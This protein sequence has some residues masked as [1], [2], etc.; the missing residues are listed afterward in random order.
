LSPAIKA[1]DA[2]AGATIEENGD[3]RLLSS[4][5]RLSKATSAG[6]DVAADVAMGEVTGKIAG[7]G[8]TKL[9]D[10]IIDTKAGRT[11]VETVVEK[12]PSVAK[13]AWKYGDDVVETGIKETLGNTVGAD[14][15]GP[16]S[17]SIE[18]SGKP[19]DSAEGN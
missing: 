2:I 14:I 19:S 6:F 9:Q 7:V 15:T 13:A 8:N 10:A 3:T 18:N 5:E 1:T 12:A 16:I 11:L 4:S 17:E